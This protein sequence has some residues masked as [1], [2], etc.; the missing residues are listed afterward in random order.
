MT[1][2]GVPL[3]SSVNEPSDPFVYQ[4]CEITTI[5]HYQWKISSSSSSPSV[6]GGLNGKDEVSKGGKTKP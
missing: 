3:I 4:Y 2:S 6:N 1:S 5:S